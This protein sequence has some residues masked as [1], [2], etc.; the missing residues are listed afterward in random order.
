M[1]GLWEEFH[2]N[3]LPSYRVMKI[4]GK[5]EGLAEAFHKNGQ[6]H[7]AHKYIEGIEEDGLS[8]YFFDNGQLRRREILKMARKKVFRIFQ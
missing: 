5:A 2:D 1:N 8:S 3:G 6:M 4:N 7:Y